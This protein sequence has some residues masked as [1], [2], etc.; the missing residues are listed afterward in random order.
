MNI[1]YYGYSCFKITAKPAGRG[2]EEINVF[3]DPFDKTIGL[4][5]PQGQ[6]D[7]VLITHDHAGHN[8]VAA[9][10]G[11]PGIIDIPGEYSI[12]G[13]SIVGIGTDHDDKGGQERGK[14]T[15]YLLDTEDVKLCHLGDLGTDLTEKQMEELDDID[16]LMIPIGGKTT[17]DA[18]KAI[19]LIRKIEPKIII[20][21]HYKMNGMTA[22]ID[23]EKNFCNEIGN[24]SSV[25]TS[26][27]NIKKKDLEEKNMEILVMTID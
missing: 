1:Q 3:I 11:N 17:I 8:N 2:Q 4:R 7:V 27:L 19:E 23:D 16:I 15:I 25:K 21:M 6:A 24:C 10:K 20:P 18:K 9:L 12:K 13:V 14:N 22:D 5:P 26:K